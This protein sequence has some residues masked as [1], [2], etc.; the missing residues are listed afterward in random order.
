[1]RIT[2][3]TRTW[4][5][6]APSSLSAL[7]LVMAVLYPF[8]VSPQVKVFVL[9]V[10]GL[11]DVLDGYFARRLGVAGWIGGQLDAI[12]DKIMAL[13]VLLTFLVQGIL[14]PWEVG[15]LISRDLVVLVIVVYAAITRQWAAFRIMPARLFGK[16]TT[17]V[18]YIFFFS[19]IL[20]PDRIG[21]GLLFVVVVLC[22]VTAAVDYGVQFLRANQA[23]C[24][25]TQTGV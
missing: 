21:M 9:L 20:W 3:I 19:L 14:R 15:L 4:A 18:L 8:A 12:S 13:S 6:L 2:P 17:A 1:M 10:A 16:I 11:S 24:E 7:R 5:T 23:Q 25:S 22:S